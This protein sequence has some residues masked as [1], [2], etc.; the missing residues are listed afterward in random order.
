MAFFSAIIRLIVLE[1]IRTRLPWL[2]AIVMLTAFGIAQF[3]GQVAII[4]ES[5]IQ[6]TLQGAI[7]RVAAVFIIVTFVVTSMVREANDK[8]TELLLSQA[9]PRTAYFFGKLAGYAAVAAL[10]AIAFSI[11]LLLVAPAAGLLAWALSLA[12]ELTL[13]AALSLFCVLSLTQVL[14]AISA[15]AGFYFLGR[16]LA[17][18]KLIAEASVSTSPSQADQAISALVSTIALVLPSLDQMTLSAWL[19]SAPAPAA[20]GSVIVQAA[21]YTTLLA[22]ASLFDLYRKNF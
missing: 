21:L 17:A 8:V 12:C 4:E 16:S 5:Q 1:A 20:V 14:P 6:A 18:M 3:L 13:M 9:A 7:L 2:L 10:V 11:P 15:A 22:A 19:V